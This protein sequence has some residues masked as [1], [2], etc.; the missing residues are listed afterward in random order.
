MI[1][2]LI[3]YYHPQD[4]QLNMYSKKK[5][6]T[7]MLAANAVGDGQVAVFILCKKSIVVVVFHHVIAEAPRRWAADC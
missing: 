6:Q 7:Q 4:F 1:G 3:I 2:C 5:F